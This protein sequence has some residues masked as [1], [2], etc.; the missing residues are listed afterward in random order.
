MHLLAIEHL[1]GG[2]DVVEKALLY[3]VADEKRF[4]M[5]DVLKVPGVE[6]HIA[7]QAKELVGLFT[8][9]AEGSV[10]RGQEWVNGNKSWIENAGQCTRDCRLN[11]AEI[12]QAF[13]SSPLTVY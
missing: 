9:E 12:H 8:G 2:S 7:G 13:L 5:H 11:P 6:A 4:T 10:G 3:A 1:G